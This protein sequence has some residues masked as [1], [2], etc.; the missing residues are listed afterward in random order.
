MCGAEWV[1]INFRV[2]E[3]DLL[4]IYGGFDMD[5]WMVAVYVCEVLGNGA[6]VWPG[7]PMGVT[8]RLHFLFRASNSTLDLNAS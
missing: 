7:R 6:V 5:G 2:K 3:V 4:W 1:R 8:V